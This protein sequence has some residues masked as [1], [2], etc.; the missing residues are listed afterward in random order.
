VQSFMHEW[1]LNQHRNQLRFKLSRISHNVKK[2]G[3]ST[4]I[5]GGH[6]GIAC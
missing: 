1:H 2:L 3:G 4:I 6:P 5:D